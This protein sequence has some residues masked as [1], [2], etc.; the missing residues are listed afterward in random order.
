MLDGCLSLQFSEASKTPEVPG[1]VSP[2]ELVSQ[3]G[4]QLVFLLDLAKQSVKAK[5]SA[6]ALL[7]GA[8]LAE[9]MA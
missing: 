8:A 4:T 1:W 3:W 2:L 5:V 9:A 6:W 7:S